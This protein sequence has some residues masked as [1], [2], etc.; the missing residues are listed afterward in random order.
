MKTLL[1][2]PFFQIVTL[3][4]FSQLDSSTTKFIYN[5]L[6]KEPGSD[7][8]TYTDKLMSVTT[9]LIPTML[10]TSKIV[11]YDVSTQKKT[12]LSLSKSEKKQLL[13][14][15]STMDKII[16]DELLFPNSKMIPVDSLWPYISKRQ[17]EISK[18]IHAKVDQAGSNRSANIDRASYCSVFQFSKPIFLR[19][20]TIAIFY[21]L[22]ICGSECGIED[23]SVYK[24]QDGLYKRWLIVGGGVF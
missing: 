19:K 14:D 5:V 11:G 6:R 13:Q 20:G 8:I 12:E 7:T 17:N 10:Q 9:P 4:V 24:L 23:L 21:F 3:S 18:I 1:L 16:W 15:A 22:R 2:Y